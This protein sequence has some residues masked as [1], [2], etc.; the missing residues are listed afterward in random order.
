MD[1]IWMLIEF[2]KAK[3]MQWDMQTQKGVGQVED[4]EQAMPKD[5]SSSLVVVLKE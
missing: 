4:I 2:S 5:H 3:G 1:K